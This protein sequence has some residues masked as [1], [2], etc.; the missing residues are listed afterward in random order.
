MPNNHLWVK[1]EGL[2]NTIFIFYCWKYTEIHAFM[3]ARM[4]YVLCYDLMFA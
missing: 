4:N 3:S 1:Q 2:H